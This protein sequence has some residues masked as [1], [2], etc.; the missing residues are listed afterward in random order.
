MAT[1]QFHI[2]PNAK[3]NKVVGE[4]GTAIKIKLRAPALE[5]KANEG[6]AKI[7]GRTIKNFRAQHCARVRSKIARK[8]DSHR[9]FE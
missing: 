7:A 9:R 6:F 5:G 4:H 3:Q 2:V 1:L 8:T